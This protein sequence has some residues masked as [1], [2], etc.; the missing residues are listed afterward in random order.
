MKTLDLKKQYKSLY[1]PSEKKDRTHT[2]TQPAIRHDRQ[3]HRKRL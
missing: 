3:R 2:S 1:Q